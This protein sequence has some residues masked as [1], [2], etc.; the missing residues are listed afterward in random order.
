MKIIID[1]SNVANYG[2]IEGSKAKLSYILQAIKKIKEDENEFIVIADASLKHEIDEKEKYKEL[3]ENKVI[4]E[5]DSGNDADHFILKLAEKNNGKIL[6]NDYFRDFSS[7]FKDINAMRISFSFDDEGEISFGRLKKPKRVK[8][9]LQNICNDILNEIDKKKYIAYNKKNEIDFSPLHIAKEAILRLDKSNKDDI[10]SKIENLFSKIPLFDKINEL[11]SEVEN[12]APYIIFVL[13]HP[14]NYKDAVKNAGNISV[15]IGDRLKLSKNPL[16]A[17]RNDLYM[18]P[19]KFDLNIIYA[20]EVEE[21]SPYDVEIR[22]NS[23]DESFIKKSSRNIASTIAG[24]IGSWKFPIVSVKND[25]FLEKPGEF[26]V[27]LQEPIKLK[28][29]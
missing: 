15:T 28:E 20:D 29:N 12:S 8:N 25:I 24:R 2:K 4:K 21:E 9:I 3:L 6:S 1:G 5:V 26:E 16:I 7:E 13:V 11:A 10:S 22:I 17:V 18:K 27:E 23:N 19:N 14:K